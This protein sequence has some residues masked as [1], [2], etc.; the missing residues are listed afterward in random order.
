MALPKIALPIFFVELISTGKKHKFRPYTSKQQEILLI[1]LE[2]EN[3]LE[4][5]T[6]CENLLNDCV[7]GIDAKSIPMFDFEC[8]F[9]K[10]RIA[11]S[12]EIINLTVP[13]LDD[14]EC[15]YKQSVELNLN[16]IK[17]EQD[18][19]HNKTI[20]FGGDIGVTMRYPTMLDSTSSTPKELL[21]SCIESIYDKD[22]LYP[23]KDITVVELE[24][25][26][27]SLENKH[28]NQIKEF[29]DTMPKVHLEIEYT[30]NKCGKV[31][32]RVIEGFENFFTTP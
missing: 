18:P 20:D 4:I 2:G 31:E 29:F 26:V 30:C 8:L 7:E 17:I 28:I 3:K 5:I 19:K 23:T 12:G 25:W 15:D 14:A 16:D 9:I 10:L 22:N 13:H 1:A 6:A 21:L 32:K 11:S 27:G 24:E